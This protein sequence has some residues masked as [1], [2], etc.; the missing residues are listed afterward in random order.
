MIPA[1][2]AFRVP[3]KLNLPEAHF[4]CVKEQET[5]RQRLTQPGDELYCL[6]S[7]DNTNNAWQDTQDTED[8]EDILRRDK[9]TLKQNPKP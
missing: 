4:E 9:M 7:L 5:V 3:T 2:R 8:T 6:D 1:Q